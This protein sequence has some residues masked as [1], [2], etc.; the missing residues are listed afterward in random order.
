MVCIGAVDSVYRLAGDQPLSILVP[1]IPKIL[2]DLFGKFHFSAALFRCRDD[3]VTPAFHRV[4]LFPEN[5]DVSC[6]L[7]HTPRYD[8]GSI[9]PSRL[10]DRRKIAVRNTVHSF[11]EIIN[12][13]VGN[14]G[15]DCAVFLLATSHIAQPPR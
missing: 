1:G 6:H 9:A 13:G 11:K 10:S 2:I 7:V 12:A 4:I 3:I 5:P 14:H 15:G 8:A